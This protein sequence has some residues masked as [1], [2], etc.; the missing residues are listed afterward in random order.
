MESRDNPLLEDMKLKVSYGFNHNMTIHFRTENTYLVTGADTWLAKMA[1]K[2]LMDGKTC[3]IE[4]SGGYLTF[5]MDESSVEFMKCAEELSALEHKLWKK[6]YES[7]ESGTPLEEIMQE[8]VAH[9]L[10][11]VLSK[12][13]EDKDGSHNLRCENDLRAIQLHTAEIKGHTRL[14]A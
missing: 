10:G 1:R 6:A 8:I 14:R 5:E 9:T 4:D 11:S 13:L 7:I 3:I 2:V 12:D